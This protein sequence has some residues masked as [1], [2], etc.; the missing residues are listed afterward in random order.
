MLPCK[1]KAA[2][3]DA[4]FPIIWDGLFFGCCMGRFKRYEMH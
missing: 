1:E 3:S 2:S 4:L